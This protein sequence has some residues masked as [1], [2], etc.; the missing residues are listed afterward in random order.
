MRITSPPYAYS[1]SFR[2]TARHWP[3]RKNR[4]SSSAMWVGAGYRRSLTPKTNNGLPNTGKCR[5]CFP[6]KTM[7]PPAVPHRMPIIPRKPLSEV[8][9]RDFPKLVWE[10]VNCSV[11]WNL[12]RVSAISSAFVPKISMPVSWLWNLI[13]QPQPLRNTSIPKQNISISASRTANSV[14]AV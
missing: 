11:F 6:R 14:P 5:A 3:H 13:P 4:K 2:P 8:S 12:R 1:N 7:R 10:A 9:I